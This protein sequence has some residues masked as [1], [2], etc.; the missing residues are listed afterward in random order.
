MIFLALAFVWLAMRAL[1]P[2][3]RGA[4]VGWWDGEIDL[5]AGVHFGEGVVDDPEM[6]VVAQV[7]QAAHRVFV[8]AEF[9]GQLCTCPVHF[10]HA[11]VNR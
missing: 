5:Q 7:E 6:R 1:T 10:V 3:S 8:H 11:L 4:F 9:G 2:P